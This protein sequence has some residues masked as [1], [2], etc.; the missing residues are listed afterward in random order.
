MLNR[1]HV[2]NEQTFLSTAGAEAEAIIHT[3]H[4]RHALSGP[5]V[6]LSSHLARHTPAL[7]TCERG[8]AEIHTPLQ[9]ISQSLQDVSTDRLEVIRP[10]AVAPWEARIATVIETEPIK[11]SALAHLGH[12]HRNLL[13]GQK[14]GGR[15]GG[16]ID[17]TGD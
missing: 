5:I 6:D 8:D 9:K 1:W 16:A 7:E 11:A 17:D 13:V 15:S 10:Y 3:V 14:W 2:L 4:E 12:Q